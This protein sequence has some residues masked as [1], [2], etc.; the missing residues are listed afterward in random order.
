MSKII[1]LSF[2]CMFRQDIEALIEHTRCSHFLF[3]ANIA[4]KNCSI[5]LLFLINTYLNHQIRL[6]K[7]DVQVCQPFLKF[8]FFRP[9]GINV[10]PLEFI[11]YNHMN[12]IHIY[13]MLTN[14]PQ[15]SQ[16]DLKKQ[17]KM[18]TFRKGIRRYNNSNVNIGQKNYVL[19]LS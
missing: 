1:V 8:F 13:Y 6:L 15:V 10:L 14:F 11:S 5:Y 3:H 19:I 16:N 12:M 9:N 18:F 2:L 7:S 4:S 17:K